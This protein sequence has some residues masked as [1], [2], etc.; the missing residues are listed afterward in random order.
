MKRLSSMVKIRQRSQA[1]SK[2]TADTESIASPF[3]GGVGVASLAV[4]LWSVACLVGAVI[5]NGP[6]GL[7]HGLSQ[8]LGIM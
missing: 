2:S 5:S 4:G 3:L 8:A 1:K 6:L 7:I